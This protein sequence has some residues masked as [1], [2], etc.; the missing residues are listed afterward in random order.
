[1]F[2]YIS[3][4]TIMNLELVICSR[5]RNNHPEVSSDDVLDFIYL[6]SYSPNIFYPFLNIGSVF[7]YLWTSSLYLW[8]CHI[9]LSVFFKNL[10]FSVLYFLL[11][12]HFKN[13]VFLIS[14]RFQ[15]LHTADHKINQTLNNLNYLH[16][17]DCSKEYFH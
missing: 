4:Q 14:T 1:M 5:L 17:L 7:I 13:L 12:F 2:L 15:R 11:T 8:S 6:M 16:A 9:Y 10:I 3:H